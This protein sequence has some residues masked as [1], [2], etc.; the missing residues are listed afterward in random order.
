ML[1]LVVNSKFMITKCTQIF[2]DGTLKIAPKGFYQVVNIGGY[3]PEIGGI[4]PIFFIPTNG[5]SEYLY[6]KIFCD[7]KN[8]LIENK[9]DCKK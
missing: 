9:I 3:I 2:V 7:I 8:I 1:Y 4:I 5:K 6:N